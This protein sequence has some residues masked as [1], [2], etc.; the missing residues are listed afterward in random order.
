MGH[1]NM[2]LEWK[3]LSKEIFEALLSAREV[4]SSM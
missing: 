1:M 4:M 3:V 2:V